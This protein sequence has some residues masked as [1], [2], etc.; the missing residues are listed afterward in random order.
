MSSVTAVLYDVPGPKARMR[1]LLASAVFL[2]LLGLGIWWVID[3][4]SSKGQLRGELWQ[5]FLTSQM[6]TTY[7]LPGL[8]NTLKAAFFS[9]VVALPFGA[10]F[11]IARLSDHSS[12]RWV[13]GIIVEF[14]R[15]IPVLILMVFAFGFSVTV[16]GVNDP[17]LAVVIGLVLYNGSVL[18]EVFRAG[19]VALPK[20]QT[21]AAEAIGLGKTQTMT[22]I[23]LPQALTAMLHAIV[24]QL[25]VILKDTALGG[26]LIGFVELR[27]VAG[28]AAAAYKNVVP[29]Y[30]V[31][32]VVYILL[33]LL[34][35][36]L[37]HYLERRARRKRGG[38]PGSEEPTLAPVTK[39]DADAVRAG[40]I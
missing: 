21:E 16:L 28:T 26:I 18:A 14:F 12:I 27:R 11:G 3:T 13:A 29:T 15:A 8:I 19:V 32:A 35:T 1:H 39:V 20:G 9:V 5:P 40:R 30:I 38:R 34:L 17:L 31:I 36:S 6:W 22:L 10:V 25:V 33:N 23:L 37:A 7:L 2:V 24:S 4:L